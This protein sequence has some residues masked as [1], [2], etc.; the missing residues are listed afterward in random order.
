MTCGIYCINCGSY[1]YVGQSINIEER[2]KAHIRSLKR[3][4]HPNFIM[5]ALWLKYGTQGFEFLILEECHADQLTQREQYWYDTLKSYKKGCNLAPIADSPSR[6]RPCSVAAKAKISAKMKN[7]I[8]D[9]RR[10]TPNEV[11]DIWL[12]YM[13]GESSKSI[14]VSYGINDKSVWYIVT[15]RY[16][17]EIELPPSCRQKE[18]RRPG[19]GRKKKNAEP[20]QFTELFASAGIPVQIGTGENR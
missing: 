12:R 16:Y 11:M 1:P 9:K 10:F 7:R 14:A 5:Q 8:D 2:W 6:G 20:K 18:H 15:R 17:R 13:S 19:G 3:G 4:T